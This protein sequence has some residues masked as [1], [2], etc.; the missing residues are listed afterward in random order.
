[1]VDFRL[2]SFLLCH[3]DPIYSIGARARQW[4]SSLRHNAAGDDFLH[5]FYYCRRS[6]ERRHRFDS[7]RWVRRGPI[8]PQICD[9]H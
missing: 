1:M 2:R 3:Q 7:C 9:P 5:H 4:S 6:I 8:L